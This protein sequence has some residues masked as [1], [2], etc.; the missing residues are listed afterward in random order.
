MWKFQKSY[1]SRE[2][3]SLALF[4]CLH[5]HLSLVL[6]VGQE[7]HLDPASLASLCEEWSAVLQQALL[8][9]KG[10]EAVPQ[11]L[12]PAGHIST[13]CTATSNGAATAPGDAAASSTTSGTSS[14]SSTSLHMG[15]TLAVQLSCRSGGCT[16]GDNCCCCAC[17]LDLSERWAAALNGLMPLGVAAAATAG[18]AATACTAATAGTAAAAGGGDNP[19]ASRNPAAAAEGHGDS[20]HDKLPTSSSSSSRGQEVTGARISAAGGAGAESPGLGVGAEP[21][22]GAAAAGAGGAAGALRGSLLAASQSLLHVSGTETAA[23]GTPMKPGSLLVAL[24]AGNFGFS[25]F[26]ANGVGASIDVAAL[27]QRLLQLGQTLTFAVKA[28]APEGAVAAAASETAAAEAAVAAEVAVATRAAAV[29][30]A[31]TRVGDSEAGGFSMDG[32]SSAGGAVAAVAAEGLPGDGGEGVRRRTVSW[33][34]IRRRTSEKNLAAAGDGTDAG[35]GILAAAAAA[36]VVA[37]SVGQAAAAGQTSSQSTGQTAGQSAGQ[38]ATVDQEGLAMACP[39]IESLDGVESAKEFMRALKQTMADAMLVIA[40]GQQQQLLLQQQQQQGLSV[41]GLTRELQ[42]VYSH[43][44]GSNSQ[45]LQALE[46]IE[47]LKARVQALQEGGAVAGDLEEQLRQLQQQLAEAVAAET[48]ARGE[49]VAKEQQLQQMLLEKQE[50]Q[51]QL[52][53]LLKDKEEREQLLQLLQQQLVAV[54]KE[55]E[56]LKS[57]IAAKGSAEGLLQEKCSQL[58]AQLLQLQQQFDQSQTLVRELQQQLEQLQ[59]SS[60][61]KDQQILLMTKELERLKKELEAARAAAEAAAAN[62]KDWEAKYLQL[63]RDLDAAKEQHQRMEEGAMASG[64]E[65]VR[66][67]Q[68]LQALKQLQDELDKVQ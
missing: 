25:S 8:L 18:T 56:D 68:E 63:Q 44:A 9:V 33:D 38:S 43:L 29:A 20:T 49:V 6:A 24:N 17:H 7:K 50:Q 5:M 41:N 52:E 65:L 31:A 59:A 28:A 35:N 16:A 30:A 64:Q 53:Q 48:T 46:V 23:N 3:I 58:E 67:R 55:L 10:M 51:Q 13:T 36:S 19:S 60:A 4:M 62:A 22:A 1:E 32:S 39:G 54:T 45:L 2:L 47:G 40:A 57:A 26:S 27:K 37:G 15:G 42:Q 21:I 11:L 14:S 12:H 61:S 66:T 34:Q